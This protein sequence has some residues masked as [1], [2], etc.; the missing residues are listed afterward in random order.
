MLERGL[1]DQLPASVRRVVA[2]NGT[3]GMRVPA[4]EI[5]LATLQ[6]LVGPI[7]L[8]SANRSGEP[9]AVTAEQAVASLRRS[10]C[11]GVG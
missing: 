5:L 6:M 1:I 8:T 9:A 4:H 10:R 7:A 2:P 3:V 11:P